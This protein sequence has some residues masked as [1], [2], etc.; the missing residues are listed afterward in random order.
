[1]PYKHLSFPERLVIKKMLNKGYRKSEIAVFLGRHRS[2]VSRELK[3]NRGVWWYRPLE[4]HHKY[5]IR[6]RHHRM[7]KLNANSRL[8]AYIIDRIKNYHSPDEIAHR[9]RLDNPQD[10][11]MRVSHE[12]IYIWLYENARQGGTW[13]RFLRRSVKKRH[14]RILKNSRRITIPG[15]KSIHTRPAAVIQRD[16]L[17]DWEGDLITGR[18][19]DGH[20]V[21]MVDR[22]SGYLA[23]APVPNKRPDSL[24]RAVMEAYGDIANDY[25]HTI[26]VDNGTEFFNFKDI[27]EALECEVYFADPYSAW[28]RGTNENTNG[29][30]RQFLPRT[31]SFKNLDQNEVDRFVSLL[32]HRPR[33]RLGY[34]TPYEVFHGLNVALDN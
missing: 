6:K 7:R 19:Q 18:C 1:M 14:R 4:A 32:N 9:M 30:L 10:K 16:R 23:A 33:K 26:T 22:K 29:L 21:T 20:V 12:S 34:R 25:I 28:Q 13:Y 24:N 31:I 5:E 17:G 27:E 3:R 11:S 2:T 8:Q 15:K